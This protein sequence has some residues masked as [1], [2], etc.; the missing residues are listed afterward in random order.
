MRKKKNLPNCEQVLAIAIASDL[1][2]IRDLSTPTATATGSGVINVPWPLSGCRTVSIEPDIGLLWSSVGFCVILCI[3]QIIVL[4][5]YFFIIKRGHLI[6]MQP[7]VTLPA[8]N[9]PFESIITFRGDIA[10]ARVGY[11]ELIVSDC[12]AVAVRRYF[13]VPPP[14]CNMSVTLLSLAFAAGAQHVRR[15]VQCR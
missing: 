5:V 1:R 7:K 2:E 10:D 11:A 12:V 3:T 8:T 15:A 4:S 14:S 13:P 6:I 9:T